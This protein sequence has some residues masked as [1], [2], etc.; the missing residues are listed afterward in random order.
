MTQYRS[1]TAAITTFCVL[2]VAA[3]MPASA[4]SAEDEAALRTL[5]TDTWPAIYASNDADA[6][7]A[8]LAEDFVLI[9]GGSITPKAEEVD[10]MRKNTWEAPEDFVYEVSDVVF[11]T[12]DA[13]IVYGRGL[14]TRET[15][16]GTPC[17]HS[18]W[19]SNTIRREGNDWRPVSSHVSDVS[20]EPLKP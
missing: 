10:W 12:P 5:K 16:N 6:L 1:L 13:A 4:Q 15:E 11:I 7:D 14:S 17:R 8:F 3:H 18:Y 20:C 2:G 9:A 19:S